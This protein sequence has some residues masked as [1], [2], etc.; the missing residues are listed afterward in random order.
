MMTLA[1]FAPVALVVCF[2]LA[3]FK[4]DAPGVIARLALKNFAVLAA[5]L[6]GGCVLVHILSRAL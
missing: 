2:V 6:A 4:E 5:A 3:I 1:L